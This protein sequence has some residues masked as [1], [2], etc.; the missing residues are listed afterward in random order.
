MNCLSGKITAARNILSSQGKLRNEMHQVAVNASPDPGTQQSTDETDASVHTVC[1]Y[2]QDPFPV[3][4]PERQ[5]QRFQV[6]A[7]IVLPIH[8]T[9]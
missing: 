8:E 7:D 3:S 9:R 6:G 5:K 2:H 1:N 4:A